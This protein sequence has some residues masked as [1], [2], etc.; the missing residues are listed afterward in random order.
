MPTRA[1]QVTIDGDARVAGESTRKTA[2]QRGYSRRWE[3]ASRHWRMNVQKVCQLCI[4]QGIVSPAECVDHVIPHR[5]DQ[6][7]FWD[8]SNWQSLCNQCHNAKTAR[9]Q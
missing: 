7:L 4:Q 9:G 2:R 3:R 6:R 1:K 5:G 8:E